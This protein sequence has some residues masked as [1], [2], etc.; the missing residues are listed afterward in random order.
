MKKFFSICFSVLLMFCMSISL[1]GCKRV[2][3]IP[4]GYYGVAHSIPENPLPDN[5]FMLVECDI[6]DSYGWV[7]EGDKAEKWVSGLCE[8]KAKI[9]EKD[10]KIYFEGYKW[11]DF[12]DVIFNYKEMQGYE[13]DYAVIYNETEKSIALTPVDVFFGK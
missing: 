7:V 8:Y 3:P 4:N 2:G 6:R 9:V 10:G 11:R 12:F 1:F 5:Y 13:S